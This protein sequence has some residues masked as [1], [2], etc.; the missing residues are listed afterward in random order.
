MDWKFASFGA[1]LLWGTYGI[2]GAK[3]GEVH[4]EK[5]NM[6]FEAFAM[7][8]V[9]LF[10]LFAIKNA[11]ADFSKITLQS[12]IFALI[13]GLMSAGGMF[14]QLY[15]LRV[16]PDQV[17][18]IILISGMFPMITVITTYFMGQ[19]FTAQ[20]W[21]GICFAVFGLILINLPKN[22]FGFLK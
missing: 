22:I 17:G 16:A 20:Q 3:A 4:G 11:T 13:M 6:A 2:F 12:S 15:A 14:L 8:L 21:I 19:H 5:V 18:L 1:L 7:V 10:V 9:S